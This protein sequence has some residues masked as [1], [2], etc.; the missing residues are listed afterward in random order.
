M[1][2]SMQEDLSRRAF[3]R[4]SVEFTAGIGATMLMPCFP[5]TT[6]Q[7]LEMP[8]GTKW[9]EGV[10]KL[11]DAAR[12]E[13]N[14]YEAT[15]VGDREN[16]EWVHAL[17]G[18]HASVPSSPVQMARVALHKGNPAQLIHGAVFDHTHPESTV[19]AISAKRAGRP[20]ES[21]DQYTLDFL[22]TP[23]GGDLGFAINGAKTIR[24]YFELSGHA[25]GPLEF[26][27]VAARGR[28]VVREIAWNADSI[29]KHPDT[30]ARYK[31]QEEK[32]ISTYD[33]A[34]GLI[35]AWLSKIPEA[36]E[37]IF[38]ESLQEWKDVAHTTEQRV[39]VLTH[40]ML[41]GRSTCKA[42]REL[43][44]RQD[45]PNF[46]QQLFREYSR[47]AVSAATIEFR[48]TELSEG[49]LKGVLTSDEATTA[50]KEFLRDTAYA[51]LEWEPA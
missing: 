15:F 1:L 6:V 32:R 16:G 51:E 20:A 42:I 24:K 46:L 17:E 23:A 33:A 34:K 25:Y 28:W 18:K 7:A 8:K 39:D 31:S 13:P 22:A 21:I 11:H 41:L 5:G 37:K 35:T 38:S 2:L 9:A 10:R 43:T 44:E 40:L 14:E 50:Y 30:Y 45:A 48:R 3:L 47:S 27:S 12:D 49:V 29:A 26:A 4:K 36:V 19:K